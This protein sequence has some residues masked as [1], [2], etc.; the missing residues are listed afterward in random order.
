[1]IDPKYTTRATSILTE[2]E[3]IREITK[4]KVTISIEIFTEDYTFTQNA[5]I[6]LSRLIRFNLRKWLASMEGQ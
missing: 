1:M 3:R 6:N 4:P 5:N 2:E